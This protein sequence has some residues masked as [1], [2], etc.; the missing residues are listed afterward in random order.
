MRVSQ[1]QRRQTYQTLR[2]A[3]FSRSFARDNDK[4]DAGRVQ[5]LLAEIKRFT[6]P[7][8]RI[9]AEIAIQAQ[10]PRNRAAQQHARQRSIPA[11][12]RERRHP[13]PPPPPPVTHL[14]PL[15]PSTTPPPTEHRSA[16]LAPTPRQAREE[17][18]QRTSK[19]LS[20]TLSDLRDARNKGLISDDHYADI[21][22]DVA[23]ARSLLRE[24]AKFGPAYLT[25]ADYEEVTGTFDALVRLADRLRAR[26]RIRD[27]LDLEDYTELYG[28]G[29]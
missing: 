4:A 14:P 23:R 8:G 25:R 24:K 12:E 9:R 27:F 7:Q 29:E 16:P 13:A 20:R 26:K 6:T 18:Y 22:A 28:S 21:K 10:N 1:D 3:G 15:P 17:W 19:V 11:T 2:A 5:R